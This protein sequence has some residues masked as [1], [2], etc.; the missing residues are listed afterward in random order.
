MPARRE[1]ERGHEPRHVTADEAARLVTSRNFVDYFSAF[2][3][4]D[5]FDVALAARVHELR[6]VKIRACLTVAP[7]AVLQAD[8]HGEHITFFNWHFS[9]YDRKMHDARIC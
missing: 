8:P 4:P 5:V 2:A 6:D 3:Q 9:G 1:H 7:R